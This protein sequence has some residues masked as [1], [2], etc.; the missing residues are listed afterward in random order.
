LSVGDKIKKIMLRTERNLLA[1]SCSRPR[2][3]K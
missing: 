3:F 2:R 1:P